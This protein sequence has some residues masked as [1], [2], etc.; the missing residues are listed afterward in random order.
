MHR[1]FRLVNA[2]GGLEAVAG[3]E[4]LCAVFVD[5]DVPWAPRGA[6]PEIWLGVDALELE[7]EFD[8]GR[9]DR[10][11]KENQVSPM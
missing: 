5:C 2:D 6:G 11:V 10:R 8:D 1:D 7:Q 3:L 9:I 4:L